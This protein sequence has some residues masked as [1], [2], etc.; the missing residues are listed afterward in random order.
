MGS[1]AASARS[2][3]PLSGSTR[4]GAAL[5]L[6]ASL[7]AAPALAFDLPGWQA[8]RATEALP[9][10]HAACTIPASSLPRALC[11]EA[12]ALPATEDALRAWLAARFAPRE[13]G[14][15]LL[16]GYFEPVLRAS[17]VRAPGFHVPLRARP[18]DLRDG[19]VQANGRRAM[20]RDA[21][22]GLIPYPDRAAIEAEPPGEVLGWLADPADKFFLQIQGSGRLL[23]PDG[24]LRR[25]GFAGHNGHAYVAVGRLLIER[26]AIPREAMSMQAI[27]AWM[28]DAGPAE[29]A[30]LMAAN[31][32]YVFFRDLALPAG[33]GPIGTLGAP[34]TAGRSLAV[35]PAHIP[36]GSLVWIAWGAEARLVV[37]MDTGGAIRGPARGDL[38]TGTGE[39]AGEVAGRMR[40]MARVFVLLPNTSGR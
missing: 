22:G 2:A 7:L 3:E 19:E 23:L 33:D 27:R 24:T 16:T 31:P 12:A 1:R 13:A 18:A 6:A 14:E 9:A 29:A 20:W 4:T 37:A 32:S 21:P 8:D 26:G 39:A 34:L 30:A 40:E 36:L 10:L 28:A 38:F 15:G 11:D 17:P 25:V 5:A 35:D